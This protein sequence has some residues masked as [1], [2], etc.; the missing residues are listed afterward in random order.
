MAEKVDGPAGRIMGKLDHGESIDTEE[1]KSLSVFIGY[2]K[3]RVPRFERWYNEMV[4][5]HDKNLL[6][7]AFGDPVRARA[8]LTRLEG[9]TGEPACVS[10]EEMVDFVASDDYAV[11]VHRN[12]SLGAMPAVGED[13]AMCVFQMN[14]SVLHAPAKRSFITTDSP[15]A[16]FPPPEDKWSP[17]FPVGITT[18]DSV[19]YV[20]LTYATAL[21][22][23]D[24][25]NALVHEQAT[26]SNIR[27]INLAVASKAAL[28][29]G[30]DEA[31]VRS[32]V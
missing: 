32:M 31:L 20:P 12:S 18:P 22:I 10:P 7:I 24:A 21:A 19:K 26:D 30:R 1:R 27:R 5:T 2:M 14:W 4:S 8:S 6:R 17:C 29:I 13:V 3:S 25:G 9:Y 16:L 15:F 11:D 23:G 28:V